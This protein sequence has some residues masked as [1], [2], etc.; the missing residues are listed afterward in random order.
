[1]DSSKG[2]SEKQDDK[3]QNTKGKRQNTKDKRQ[4]TKYKLQIRD[5]EAYELSYAQLGLKKVIGFCQT[6]FWIPHVLKRGMVV[7]FG[8]IIHGQ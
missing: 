2:L 1:M 3:I 4:K 6:P 7:R 8:S 5:L